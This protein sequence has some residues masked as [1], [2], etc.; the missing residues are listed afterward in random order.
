[1]FDFENMTC[2]TLEPYSNS[3]HL[4][5]VASTGIKTRSKTFTTRRLAEEYMYKQMNAHHLYE[6]EK[7]N[8]GHYQTFV[9]NDG[10][11]FY[12]NRV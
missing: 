4:Y 10:V 1:M 5:S 6:I 12:V 8:D 3:K 2:S 11:K 9:C 7:W